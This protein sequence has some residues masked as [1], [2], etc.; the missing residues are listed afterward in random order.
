MQVKMALHCTLPTTQIWNHSAFVMHHSHMIQHTIQKSPASPNA[1][2]TCLR[3]ASTSR[4]EVS[5]GSSCRLPQ[6][7]KGLPTTE[8]KLSK[9]INLPASPSRN[10]AACVLWMIWKSNAKQMEASSESIWRHQRIPTKVSKTVWNSDCRTR[11]SDLQRLGL[12]SF[13]LVWF[14]CV[15]IE[16]YQPM[17]ASGCTRWA[18][19]GNLWSPWCFG[20]ILVGVSYP[21]VYLFKT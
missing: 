18:K 10:Q 20:E 7:L 12:F 6:S 19:M 3:K 15:P 14:L 17:S 8:A 9:V 21:I 13:P 11:N 16:I 1:S 5:A 2:R 4:S